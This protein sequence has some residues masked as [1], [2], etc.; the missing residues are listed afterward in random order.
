MFW[1]AVTYVIPVFEFMATRKLLERKEGKTE[2][3]ERVI[4]FS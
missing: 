2:R 1:A 4:F 3:E